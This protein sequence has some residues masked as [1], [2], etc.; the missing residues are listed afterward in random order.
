[1]ALPDTEVLTKRYKSRLPSLANEYAPI[2]PVHR[3]IRD[4]FGPRTARFN[5]EQ[6]NSGQ[7]QDSHIINSYPRYVVRVLANGMQSGITSPMR[8]WFKLGAPDPDL[9]KRQNVKLWLEEVERIIQGIF[10]KSN[11]YNV[12]KSSYGSLSLYGTSATAIIE[13]DEDVLRL[14]HFPTGSYYIAT[15]HNGRVNCCYR[16]FKMTAE[17]MVT[18][19][20]DRAPAAARTAYDQGQYDQWFDVCHVVEPNIYGDMNSAMNQ[21]KRF[22]SSYIDPMCSSS[23]GVLS[24]GGFD[25]FPILAPRW[26]VLGEDVYGTG[27]GEVALGDGKQLQLIEKRKLQ[28]IDQNVRPT[29]LADASMRNQRTSNNPGET[30]YVNGLITGQPG[31]RKAFET[32]PYLNELREERMTLEARL[33][34]AFFKNLFLMVERF[35]DQP[36]ITATQI[37]TLREEKLLQLGPVL[38]R[39]NDEQ[40]DPA[41]D[42]AFNFANERGMLPEPPEELMGLPLQVEY[43]SILAQAQRALGISNIERFVGFVGNLANFDPNVLKKV[44][45][46]AVVDEYGE[47]VGVSP[48]II[49][50]TEDVMAEVEQD[51]QMAQMQQMAE[52]APQLTS[53]AKNLATSPTGVDSAL[54]NLLGAA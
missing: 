25:H 52:M 26:D 31:Y 3:D 14:M 51:K 30:V 44:D 27:C 12:V 46:M 37:N 13:D 54:D 11:F 45:L 23:D 34:E 16:N 43:I 15:D 41:I 32:N 29:M 10:A 7:R 21:N 18:K 53:A 22:L 8:P 20:R 35:A 4:F 38:E 6:V 5:G 28:G 19:F 42:M 39:L 33:D 36:N 24:L 50:A 1:M 47:G 17:Q 2:M 9:N 49:R 48:K 40:N